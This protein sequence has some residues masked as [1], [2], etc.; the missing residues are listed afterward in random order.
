MSDIG[1]AWVGE[2]CVII[3]CFGRWVVVI[4]DGQVPVVARLSQ[5]RVNRLF[6]ESEFAPVG[7]DDIE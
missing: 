1:D 2:F 7:D 3:A 6:E 4:K 5:D